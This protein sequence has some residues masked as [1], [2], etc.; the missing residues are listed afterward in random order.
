LLRYLSEESTYEG[1]RVIFSEKVVDVMWETR[2]GF[3]WGTI[4]IEGLGLRLG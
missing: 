4:R 3:M 1:R 2:S